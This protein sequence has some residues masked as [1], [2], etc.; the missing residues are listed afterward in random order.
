[1]LTLPI[2]LITALTLGFLLTRMLLRGRGQPSL[3]VLIALCAAQGVVIALAQHYEIQMFLFVQP[4]TASMIPPVAWVSFLASAVRPLSLRK[5]LPH[6]LAPVVVAVSVAL[7]PDTLDVVIPGLFV[8]YAALIWRTCSKGPDVL[9]R[10]RLDAGDVPLRMWHVVAIALA[11]SALSDGVI[12]LS[13]ILGFGVWQPMII[14]VSTSAILLFIGVVCLSK[15]LNAPDEQGAGFDDAGKVQ[16]CVDHELYAHFEALMARE[17]LYLDPDLTLNT[18][19][20]RLRVSAKTLSAAIN[21]HT[22]EN[23]SRTINAMRIEAAGAALVSGG[24]V[25][26]AMLTSGFNT[27]SN[28]N[29]EFLRIHG[30]SPRIWM[31]AQNQ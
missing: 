30:L 7:G 13:Q 19:A 31:A 15:D 14:S 8:F 17:Q 6:A 4:V 12:V 27:K 24:S 2:P 26:S 23:V 9:T 21:T 3:L 10:L 22:G 18:L 11:L 1:M 25:T 20:R 5:D 28:F 16:R 29:R